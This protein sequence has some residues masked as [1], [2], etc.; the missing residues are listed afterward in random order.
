ME[1]RMDQITPGPS[2][3]RPAVGQ[4]P[5]LTVVRPGAQP[6]AA[7]VRLRSTGRGAARLPRRASLFTGRA[8]R[9]AARPLSRRAG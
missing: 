3:R 7:S 9:A 5:T 4:A 6:I 2:L 8:V 1:Q